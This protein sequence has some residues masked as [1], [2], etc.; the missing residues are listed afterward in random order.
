[1]KLKIIAAIIIEDSYTLSWG[2]YA[3]AIKDY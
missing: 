3:E 1:M 2:N